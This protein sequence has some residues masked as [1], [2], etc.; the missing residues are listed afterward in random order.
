MRFSLKNYPLILTL[1]VF[2]ILSFVAPH[3]L[4]ASNKK[5]KK[6]VNILSVDGGGG[7]GIIPAYMAS[8][9]EDKTK[10]SIIDTFDFFA[11]TSIGGISVLYYNVPQNIY[12]DKPKY[13]AHDAVTMFELKGHEI[14]HRPYYRP[15]TTLGGLWGSKYDHSNLEKLLKEKYSPYGL[16]SQCL[17]P[18][19][20]TS[21]DLERDEP[22]LFKS[23]EAKKDKEFDFLTW[24]V[25]RSTSAAPTYFEPIQVQNQSFEPKTYSFVDGGVVANNPTFLAYNEA[26]T[27]FGKECIFNIV[28]LGTGESQESFDYKK[29]K[30]W[31]LLKWAPEVIRIS[32]NGNS[33]LVH[34]HM[35]DLEKFDKNVNYLRIQPTLLKEESGMDNCSKE[36]L[37]K[38]KVRA[39]L[40][41]K[42]KEENITE[43]I[44]KY[45]LKKEEFIDF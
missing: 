19:L 1:I 23:W 4:Y 41:M 20:V 15:Y 43:W 38:L 31:G 25:G 13:S 28:S 17:K 14:F 18:T 5:E 44:K 3:T 9:F 12:S 2:L 42:E 39:E 29:A 8:V 34:Q 33:K 32:I 24:Q 40:E 22:Y 11:G 45:L 36:N 26:R 7:K 35:I 27:L 21:Y 16:F 37:Q 10:K 6:T 30:S